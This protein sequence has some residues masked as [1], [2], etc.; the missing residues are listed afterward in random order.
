MMNTQ[1]CRAS[2]LD[3]PRSD[4]RPELSGAGGVKLATGHGDAGN[5][6]SHGKHA[7]GRSFRLRRQHLFGTWNARGLLEKHKLPVLEKEMER[8][9]LAF[10]GISETHWRGS[11]HFDSEKHTIYFSGDDRSSFTGVAVAIPKMWKGAVLG[12]NPIS[13]RII[14]IKLSASPTPL[15]IMQVYA[16]TS[17]SSDESVEI[18]Y[19][20]LESSIAA[21]P[22]RELLL[23][24]GDFNAK[25]G[26]TTMDDGIRNIVGR[27]DLGVRN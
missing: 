4:R 15:N 1:R 20:E 13:D 7:T 10:T 16:P 22:K 3:N 26:E 25:V 27:Y 5:Q 11:G 14:S 19:R 17:T 9:K 8:C 24:I 2:L 6:A 18:F 21:V 12:Y 23:I